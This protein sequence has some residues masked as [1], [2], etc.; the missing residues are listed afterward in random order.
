MRF[1]LIFLSTLVLIGSARSNTPSASSIVPESSSSASDTLNGIV[2]TLTVA[3]DTL[4]VFDT[5]SAALTALNQT[6]QND[7]ILVSDYFYTWSLVDDQ[8]QTIVRG[9]WLIS[10]IIR[11]VVIGPNQSAMLY[12]LSYSTAD[13]F[14]SPIKPGTYTLTWNLWNGLSFRLSLVCGRS[15]H[16][17]EDSV[18]VVSPIYPLR[19]GNRW[20]YQTWYQFPNTV[21]QGDTV[22]ET[23]V[24]EEL[25][26]DEKWFLVV[27]SEING[28]RLMTAR[29]DGI[30]NYVPAFN[31]AVLRYKYPVVVNQRY[32]SVYELWTG[33]GDS[34][35]A[36][37]MSVDSI[38]ESVSTPG[39]TYEC[40]KYH[41]PEVVVSVGSTSTEVDSEDIFLSNV[42]PVKIVTG[43]AYR[44]LV[45]F[46]DPIAKVRNLTDGV[47]NV[48][49]L[50]QNYPNPF[51]P[52][53]II[54]YQVAVNSHVTLKVYDI[55]GREVA[56]LVDENKSAGSYQAKF[57][58]SR[59]ASG[60]YFYRLE[61]RQT[62]G[63]QTGSFVQTKKLLLL[64]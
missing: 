43:G 33:C 13:L 60:V 52:S 45:A 42:G 53:T 49:Q 11:T 55:L 29:Q 61:A 51:N 32:N 20:T 35:V 18:G 19:V 8:A 36:F 56:T 59:C 5:L 41:F 50:Y 3:Q 21:I 44:E 37:Q 23:V 62:E 30:Y 47:P 31:Q 6:S 24:G 17:I 7:T 1:K 15:K 38:N 46:A 54:S 40:N 64:K 63:G 28:D 4:G 57:D 58:G 27:G 34:L 14:R 26:N 22:V 25:L 10:N 2:F 9:P 48:F 12:G 39:G 16:E